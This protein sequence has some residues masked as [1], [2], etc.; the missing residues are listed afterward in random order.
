MPKTIQKNPKVL[1]GLPVIRGTRIPVARIMALV[2]MNYD[3]KD[4]Q[5]EYPQLSTFTKTDIAEI[6]A[7][8]H[9]SFEEKHQ[10]A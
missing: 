8:Y 3:L 4:L 5:R 10:Q 1:G 9:K 2:G 7:F 6:F